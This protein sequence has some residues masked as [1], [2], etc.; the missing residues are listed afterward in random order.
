MSLQGEYPNNTAAIA[1]GVLDGQLYNLPMVQGDSPYPDVALVAVAK[2]IVVQTTTWDIGIHLDAGDLNAEIGY[3]DAN[4]LIID[5][6]DGQID[7]ITDFTNAVQ[8]HTYAAEGDYTIKLS[9]AAYRINFSTM[10]AKLLSTG[11]IPEGTLGSS[12]QSLSQLF[13]NCT[14]ISSLP[15]NFLQFA[16]NVTDISGA[17]AGCTSL[18][19]V[20]YDL[21]YPLLGLQ[22]VAGLFNNSGLT[23]IPYGFFNQN[24][25]IGNFQFCFANTSISMIPANLFY[26][27][28]EAT[29]FYGC[30]MQT[31]LTAIATDMFITN[32]GAQNFASCFEGC[33]PASFNTG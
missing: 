32:T 20:N 31:Q 13:T 30:F 15:V 29:N 22:S 5:W 21:L 3:I 10:G 33:Y 2:A 6:G 8:S 26:Y 16:V 18:S 7:N 1:G 25:G 11:I 4:G 24:T 27:C 28:T 17:F 14:S 23:A 19:T 12:L 9:G